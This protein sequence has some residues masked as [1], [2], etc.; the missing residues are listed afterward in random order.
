MHSL[1]NGEY[2]KYLNSVGRVFVYV[3]DFSF[4]W[5]LVCVI[6]SLAEILDSMYFL[7]LVVA[8]LRLCSVLVEASFSRYVCLDFAMAE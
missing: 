2:L 3:S 8:C 4:D 7:Q 6:E 1:W 5:N